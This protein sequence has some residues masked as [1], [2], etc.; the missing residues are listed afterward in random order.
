MKTITDKGTSIAFAL[1]CAIFTLVPE[2]VFNHCVI[3]C[4]WLGSYVIIVNRFIISL[5][6]LIIKNLIYNWYIKDGVYSVKR[7]WTW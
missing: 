3:D 2:R 6:V 7:E 1:I 5:I 4:D